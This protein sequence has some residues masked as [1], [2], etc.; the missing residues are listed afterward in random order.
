MTKSNNSFVHL[1]V[2]CLNCNFKRHGSNADLLKKVHEQ[3][4]KNHYCEVVEGTA[5]S[6]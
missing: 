5:E 2:V 3:N 1:W 4:N 6:P